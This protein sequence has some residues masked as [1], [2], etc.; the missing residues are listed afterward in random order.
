MARP[1]SH[2]R[3]ASITWGSVESSTSGT[4]DWVAK[5]LGDLV[6]VGGAVA[7]DVVDADVEDVGALLDLVLRHLHA[8]VESPSSMASRNFFEPLALVRSPMIRNEVSCS[9][10]TSE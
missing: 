4:L 2:C 10:G 7:A 6:H 3:P 8:G 5:Q 1:P 9:N